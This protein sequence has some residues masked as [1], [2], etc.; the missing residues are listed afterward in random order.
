[1][2]KVRARPRTLL[3]GTKRLSMHCAA[4]RK[5]M[6]LKMFLSFLCNT[7]ASIDTELNAKLSM[8]VDNIPCLQLLE[9]VCPICR[10]IVINMLFA[11]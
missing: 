1:M 9:P 7:D 10:I 11:K 4:L 2:S 3:K 5:V 8:C 6:P